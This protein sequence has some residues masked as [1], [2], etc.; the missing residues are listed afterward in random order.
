LGPQHKVDAAFAALRQLES[1]RAF[2]RRVLNQCATNLVTSSSFPHR[3]Q[4][5]E[6][7]L[8][9]GSLLHAHPLQ[10]SKVFW[11]TV[12]LVCS[13]VPAEGAMALVINRP[14]GRRFGDVV[15]QQHL[16]DNQ[17]LQA[18]EH[19]SLFFGGPVHPNLLFFLHTV[20]GVDNALEIAPGLF[21]QSSSGVEAAIKDGVHLEMTLADTWQSFMHV[22]RCRRYGFT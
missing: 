15:S 17:F 16:D 19:H 6:G 2:G 14:T 13:Y 7:A 10:C 18:F 12:L 9:R 4:H 22:S 5:T 8:Q 1:N 21:L 3:L 20:A 11:R